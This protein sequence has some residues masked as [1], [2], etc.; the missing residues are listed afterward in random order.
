MQ[1]GLAYCNY[2]YQRLSLLL[3]VYLYIIIFTL[4]LLYLLYYY[5]YT[6][7]AE[8]KHLSVV[9]YLLYQVSLWSSMATGQW[10]RREEALSLWLFSDSSN[11]KVVYSDGWSL[12]R[13]VQKCPFVLFLPWVYTSKENTFSSTWL[14]SHDALS[15][16][17]VHPADA[18][19]K[20]IKDVNNKPIKRYLCNYNAWN[21]HHGQMITCK[22][23]QKINQ[24]NKYNCKVSMLVSVAKTQTNV[25]RTCRW[26]AAGC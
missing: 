24:Y 16:N 15:A 9:L 22:K 26:R 7:L 21:S 6:P 8:K 13:G 11:R 18:S 1:Q 2:P 20:L 14:E 17:N 19:N 23:E 25:W 5:T 10:A 3:V 4:Y 12:G